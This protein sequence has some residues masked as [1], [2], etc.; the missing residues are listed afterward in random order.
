MIA[1]SAMD[2]DLAVSV[3]DLDVVDQGARIGTRQ[4]QG[5]LAND[6]VRDLLGLLDE[7]IG[8]DRERGDVL[9]LHQR[10][11]VLRLRG[12]VEISV[13]VRTLV[14]MLQDGV[15]QHVLGR[16]CPCCQTSGTRSPS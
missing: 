11:R 5:D 8:E 14:T 2:V 7:L 15:T 4:D 6:A 3:R 10:L 9:V 16:M 1:S 12:L 13:A